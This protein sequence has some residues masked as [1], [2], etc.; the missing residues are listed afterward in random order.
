MNQCCVI[1]PKSSYSYLGLQNLSVTSYYPF[2]GASVTSYFQLLGFDQNQLLVV[3]FFSKICLLH[4]H[5]S[6]NNNYYYCIHKKHLKS[7]KRS[8]VGRRD[9]RSEPGCDVKQTP[10]ISIIPLLF[11]KIIQNFSIYFSRVYLFSLA[12]HQRI[13][14]RVA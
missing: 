14:I 1:A 13:K 7:V 2:F 9:E 4:H 3:T 8:E 6:N 11:Q 5:F 10:S 12:Y